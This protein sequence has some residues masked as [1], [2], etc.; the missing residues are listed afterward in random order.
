M[1]KSCA[2]NN[3]DSGETNELLHE[4]LNERTNERTNERRR[5]RAG[6]S[7]IVI[8]E[9]DDDDEDSG[10]GRG[11]WREG[12]RGRPHTRRGSGKDLAHPPARRASAA[13]AQNGL[14]QGERGDW[15][16]HRKEGD[17]APAFPRWRELSPFPVLN[18]AATLCRKRARERAGDASEST[19][20]CSAFCSAVQPCI[21][22]APISSFSPLEMSGCKIRNNKKEA[23]CILCQRGVGGDVNALVTGPKRK[24]FQYFKRTK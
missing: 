13:F 7:L 14:I 10:G 12:R 22:F 16:R 5:A 8:R 11:R 2:T 17:S 18:I 1:H 23:G 19:F 4:P 21:C 20:C 6:H 15:I 3:R 24:K 9:N